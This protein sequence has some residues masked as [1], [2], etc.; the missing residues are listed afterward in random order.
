MDDTYY[1]PVNQSKPISDLLSHIA[2]QISQ[3]RI[4]LKEPFQDFDRLTSHYVTKTQFMQVLTMLRLPITESQM[5]QLAQM[6]A[7]GSQRDNV[8]LPN[9]SFFSTTRGAANVSSPG[10]TLL[11]HQQRVNWFSFVR[12][13]ELGGDTE[14]EL[15]KKPTNEPLADERRRQADF[16]NRRQQN[17]LSSD[18]IK[19][20][21]QL[22]KRL[23]HVCKE[24]GII[25]KQL[26]EDHDRLHHGTVTKSQFIQ[27]LPFQDVDM[28]LLQLLIKRYEDKQG[29]VDY[30]IFHIEL[31]GDEPVGQLRFQGEETL[32]VVTPP[33]TNPHIFHYEAATTKRNLENAANST[34]ADVTENKLKEL[35]LKHRIRIDENLRDF[36]PLRKG[37]VTVAQFKSA[38]GIVKFPKYQFSSRELDALADKYLHVDH[39]GK[40]SVRYVDLVDSLFRIFTEKDMEKN[41]T[42]QI[43][44]PTHLL[45]T[46]KPQLSQQEE[47]RIDRLLRQIRHIVKTKRLLMKY[48]FMDFD[49]SSKDTNSSHVTPSRFERALDNLGLRFTPEEYALLERKYDDLNNGD[50]NFRLFL[51]D[52]DFEEK[53]AEEPQAFFTRKV[54]P[55]RMPELRELLENIQ[56][57]VV[58]SRIR[59]IEFLQDFDP[60][61]SSKMHNHKLRSAL[62]Q[63][64]I[65]LTDHEYQLLINA[66]ASEQ[67]GFIRYVD[68]L[69]D[70]ES[71]FH[72]RDLEKQPTVESADVNGFL[73]TRAF[74]KNDVNS[75]ELRP[76]LQRLTHFVKTHGV[77]MKPTFQ[78]YDKFHRGKISK[79]QFRQCVD[80]VL[81]TISASEYKLLEKVYYNADEDCVMYLD[82]IRDVD[83]SE[84]DTSGGTD[85]E[86]SECFVR[87]TGGKNNAGAENDLNEII[88]EVRSQVKR[89]R[90]RMR[91][92]FLDFDPLRKGYVTEN[93]FRS[94]LSSSKLELTKPQNDVLVESYRHSKANLPG[95]IDYV[96]FMDD[97][98]QIFVPN[99]LETQPLAS[100]QDYQ[101]RDRFARTNAQFQKDEHD[102]LFKEAHSK[103]VQTVRTRRLNLKPFFQEYDRR[104]KLKVTKTQFASVMSL[105]QLHLSPREVKVLSRF[106]EDVRGDVDWHAFCSD[107]ER[108]VGYEASSLP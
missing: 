66:Y 14:I 49:R 8:A 85:G 70:V 40:E 71:I 2:T 34:L 58:K 33:G 76:L 83:P 104:R 106:Y 88:E 19:T 13:V 84:T 92:Y 25:V 22:I 38:I 64:G 17:H 15:E 96:S 28:N 48:D 27:S 105:L 11:P 36:D 42:A 69:N 79:S 108:D 91:E 53:N 101:P 52:V 23:R 107:I 10:R 7:E 54:K 32:Q 51:Q 93:K 95:A 77:F 26:F 90:I 1:I 82:L 16:F 97:V 56:H 18:E 63:A 41:P 46:S 9:A 35:V 45:S 59:L 5:E 72:T 81:P 61:R 67:L 89:N 12:D 4:R 44:S 100:V 47:G 80:K 65:E 78:S 102:R 57:T 3:Q 37:Q 74:R 68:F 21:K 20:F 60:L 29:L 103:I 50:V 94:V 75:D 99:G 73:S 62:S 6:Y 24:R 31:M 98:E 87:F 86:G 30:L 43:R 55:Q 39:M